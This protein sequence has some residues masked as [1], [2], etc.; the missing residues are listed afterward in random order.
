MKVDE[1]RPALRG[2]AAAGGSLPTRSRL[3]GQAVVGALLVVGC[4]LGGALLFVNA[5]DRVAVLVV[6]DQVSAG[7]VIERDDLTTREVA[8]LKDAIRADDVESVVGKTARVELVAGQVLSLAMM[9]D[10]PVPG[11]GEALSGLALT[12]AQM[13]GAGVAPGDSVRLLAVA[14]A[15]G[16]TGAT[17]TQVLAASA[18]V[19]AVSSTSSGEASKVVTIVLPQA[20]ADRVATFAASGRVALV[21]IAPQ[22]AR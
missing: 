19:Y 11:P 10:E 12:S 18:R 9:T 8:G 4:A 21:K 20:D 14:G 13:P 2:R 6:N 5:G 16:A 3:R 15:D 17:T 1:T 7:H 22:G